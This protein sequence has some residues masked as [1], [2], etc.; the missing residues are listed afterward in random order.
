[1]HVR[2]FAVRTLCLV[3]LATLTS[4]AIA[5]QGAA[6]P[7]PATP[8]EFTTGTGQRIRVTTAASGLVHPFSVGFLDARTMVATERPGRLRIVRDGQL[9]AEPAWQA[10][11][12][13]KG[14]GAS[15][16]FVAVHPQFATN[17]LIY[18][19]YAKHGER[20]NTLAVA[21]GKLD[22]D[23][24]TEVKDVL[25]ADAWEAS[26]NMGGRVFFGRD[27][28]LYVT[29]GDRDRLCCTGTEDNSLRLKAQALDNHVGK[30]LRL[31]DDGTVPPDNPFVGRAGAKPEIFTYGHRNGYGLS[32]HPETGELWQAE[33]GPLG[34]DEVNVLLPGH[35]YGWPVVSMGRNYTGSL[36]SNEP[37]FQKGMDNPRMF[38]VPSI[39]PSSLFFYNGDRFKGWK[40]SMFVGALTTRTL[41]R[42]SFNQPSQAERR[43]ALLGTLNL[44]IRD[45]VEGPDGNLYVATERQTGGTAADGTV[46]R[47]E[48]IP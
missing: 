40:G 4:I 21:R 31:K 44:R 8:M 46:L 5:A 48:P 32:I 37:W 23:R 28:T 1:M 9:V 45:I 30:T 15:I 14:D 41:L 16:G 39:S 27:N 43:E 3:A 42:V 24:L 7:A 38:W 17:R 11:A 12:T 20:G 18:V 35:N 22:G 26:G 2:L 29:V 36:V 47:I 33:I 6:P 19:S 34:G 25:V 13:P 10:P